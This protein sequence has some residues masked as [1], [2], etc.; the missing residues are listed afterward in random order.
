MITSL[1]TYVDYHHNDMENHS[2]SI[3]KRIRN[4]LVAAVLIT[5]A[6]WVWLELIGLVI[7]HSASDPLVLADFPVVRDVIVQL[8]RGLFAIGAT[9][10]VV[11]AFDISNPSEWMGIRQPDRWEWG[12]VPL[13]LM[14]AFVWLL[15]ALILIQNVLGLER[16]TVTTLSEGVRYSRLVTLLLLVGPAEE[17]I[18]HGVIQRSLEEVVDLWQAILIGGLLFGV[19]HLDPAA[20]GSGDLLFYAAQGGFGVIVGWIYARNN[21]LVIPALVHGLFV[22]I[23]TALPLLF[24]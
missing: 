21:N 24:G 10:A 15:G 16:T 9:L 14:L 3:G 13:G 6:L 1:S 22:A 8:L 20:M 12:Y 17:V 5:V 11:R 4:R 7:G 23:T 2:Q 19:A 18:F